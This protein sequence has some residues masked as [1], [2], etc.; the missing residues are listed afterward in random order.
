MATQLRMHQPYQA[1]E[2]QLAV[3]STALAGNVDG[4]MQGQSVSLPYLEENKTAFRALEAGLGDG[5]G[6]PAGGGPLLRRS[7]IDE[8]LNI[9]RNPYRQEGRSYVPRQ[10]KT[11]KFKAT[12][13][14][15]RSLSQTES[16]GKIMPRKN[17]PFGSGSRRPIGEVPLDHITQFTYIPDVRRINALNN[18]QIKE[19]RQAIKAHSVKRVPSL[20]SMASGAQSRSALGRVVSSSKREVEGTYGSVPPQP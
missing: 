14:Q 18:A 8:L 7:S 6:T 16:T 15:V 1:S 17:V 3:G 9:V 10:P 13:V 20:S 19:Q 4:G 2:E 5:H 11:Q 12:A